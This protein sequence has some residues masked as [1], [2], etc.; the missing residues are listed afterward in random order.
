MTIEKVTAKDAA[1]ILEIY[2]YYI[3]ATAVTFDYDVPS[4]LEFEEKIT[5]IAEKYPYIKAVENGK[6]LG[7][8]Y[9]NTFKDRRAY[10][11]AVET[12][13]YL[14][15]DCKR[16]GIGRTLYAALEASLKNM[17]IKNLNACIAVP[18]DDNDKN[19]SND[20]YFFH[21]EMGYKLIG[22]F[23]DVGSKFGKWYDMI[24]M[25]KIIASHD[26]NPTDVDFGNWFLL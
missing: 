13:I 16:L 4:V 11:W 20:S 12:T 8:A 15:K 9:A 6:I 18:K 24:W 22:T 19:L 17:G 25:E 5:R 14:D 23:H 2:K 3:D 10:D 7:Y 21:K 26:P 1:E